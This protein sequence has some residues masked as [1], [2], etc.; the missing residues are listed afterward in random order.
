MDR[1]PR[2]C[3]RA[4]EPRSP[5]I[6]L[7][8]TIATQRHHIRRGTGLFN[9]KLRRCVREKRHA[10]TAIVNASCYSKRY[11]I[12][13]TDEADQTESQ[14]CLHQ[15]QHTDGPLISLTDALQAVHHVI[16]RHIVP[17]EDSTTW[18][19]RLKRDNP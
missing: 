3:K 10:D 13:L 4:G 11:L 2:R 9:V 7:R 6:S 5:G 14:D 15:G 17:D 12:T 18:F 16:W 8:S 1:D 19:P